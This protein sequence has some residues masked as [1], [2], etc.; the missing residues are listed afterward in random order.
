MTTRAYRPLFRIRQVVL[1]AFVI[2]IG[3]LLP[4]PVSAQNPT[5]SV[6]ISGRV[7]DAVSREPLG[8]ALVLSGDSAAA[9]FADS[10]GNFWIPLNSTPPYVVLA[11]QFGYEPTTFELPDSAPS[12]LSILV[13]EPMPIPVPGITVVQETEF[14]TLVKGLEKRRRGYP[15]SL[16]VYDADRLLRVGAGTAMDLVRQ[17]LAGVHECFAVRSGDGVRSRSGDLCR[18][19]RGSVMVCIDDIVSWSGS[20]VTDLENLR[21]EEIF[22][23]EVYGPSVEWGPTARA[24]VLQGGGIAPRGGDQVR[25]YTLRGFL[26]RLRGGRRGLW[27]IN[28]GNFGC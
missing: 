15:G 19:Y 3:V 18:A 27:P 12:H 26:R 13:L 24:P 28:F 14:T 2:A 17:G 5:N 4:S 20:A 16:T 6:I 1:E 23:V 22:L 9:V 25:F 21:V 10:L 11:E 7:E 8:R